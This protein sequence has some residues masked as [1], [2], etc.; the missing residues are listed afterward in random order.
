MENKLNT[1][2]VITLV[3]VSFAIAFTGVILM[4]SMDV[5][6]GFTMALAG[7]VL[8]IRSMNRV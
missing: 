2:L 4:F 8:A 7:V 3:L 1:V 5:W 6:L